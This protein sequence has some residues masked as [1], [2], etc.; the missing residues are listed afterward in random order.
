MRITEGRYL[1][2]W[3]VRVVFQISSGANGAGGRSTVPGEP[4]DDRRQ[5]VAAARFGVRRGIGGTPT[6]GGAVDPY[7]P[8]PEPRGALHVGHERVSDV[9]HVPRSDPEGFEGR[10]EDPRARFV[11]LRRLRRNHRVEAQAVAFE[12]VQE[13][14]VIRIRDDGPRDAIQRIED[15][16]DFGVRF[17]LAP[18]GDEAIDIRLGGRLD[19]VLAKRLLE[20]VFRDLRQREEWSGLCR[21]EVTVPGREEGLRVEAWPLILA[22]GAGDADQHVPSRVDEG[23]ERVERDRAH[24]RLLPRTRSSLSL[25]TAAEV[26]EGLH[27]TSRARRVRAATQGLRVPHEER[28]VLLIRRQVPGNVLF[29]GSLDRAIFAGPEESDPAADPFGV[30]VD[31]EDWVAARVQE[32]RVRDLRADAILVQKV[33]VHHVGGTGEVTGEVAPGP[34]EEMTAERSEARRLRAVEAG[35]PHVSPDD[36]DGCLSKRSDIEEARSPQISDCDLD[37]LP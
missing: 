11:R 6:K 20:A 25:S 35:D 10:L 2:M 28:V 16:R 37:V 33:G 24:H 8:H 27:W 30:R 32:D 13:E 7:G 29:E 22:H 23:P 5:L 19:A 9:D 36:R 4:P 14:L 12:D 1:T 21:E 18:Q 26:A 15:P 17:R 34:V 31:D 3:A